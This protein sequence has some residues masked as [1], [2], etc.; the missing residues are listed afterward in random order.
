MPW[1]EVNGSCLRYRVDGDGGPVVLLVHE[2]GGCIESFDEVA[3]DLATGF[4][5][6]RYDQRGFGHSEP[7]NNFTLATA[8]DD[9]AALVD[10]LALPCPIHV[11]GCA[12]GGDIA[13][14]FCRQQHERVASL[15]ITSPRSEPMDEGRKA[16]LAAMGERIASMG[17]RA[18]RDSYLVGLY[19]ECLRALDPARFEQYRARWTCNDAAAYGHLISM[20]NEIDPRSIY[21]SIACETLVLAGTFDTSRPVAMAC[22]VADM[23]P[24]G[25]FEAL[26][27]GH[28][29]AVQ[30]PELFAASV[31]RFVNA[32][33]ARTA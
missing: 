1:A 19:P 20:L 9:L 25:Q 23:I 11:A 12:L 27:S 29:M 17:L 5:V 8:V 3:A 6:V 22:A 2:A 28:F 30:T 4:R 32:A 18:I 26:E 15:V 31:R 10:H 21:P 14:V 33:I 24:Q 7:S 13:A 16:Q